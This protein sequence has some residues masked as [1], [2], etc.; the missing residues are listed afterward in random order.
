MSDLA[1]LN[2]VA[3][4]LPIKFKNILDYLLQK[5]LEWSC[6]AEVDEINQNGVMYFVVKDIYFPKQ[7]NSSGATEVTGDEWNELAEE[8][9]AKKIDLSKCHFSIHSHN[10]MGAFWSAQ[11]I[12]QWSDWQTPATTH[13]VSMVMSSKGD[14][15][16]CFHLYK[17]VRVDFDIPIIVQ[18]NVTDQE[19]LDKYKTELEAKERFPKQT[20][21]SYYYPN[22]SRYSSDAYM[23]EDDYSF[24]WFGERK[25]SKKEKKRNKRL[26]EIVDTLNEK[27]KTVFEHCITVY[28]FTPQEAIEAVIDCRTNGYKPYEY[29]F[30]TSPE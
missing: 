14:W 17:P 30:T 25:M 6:L 11:D 8:L 15:K 22:D 24:D 9:H 29:L 21:S 10:S 27:E 5:E 3:V 13:R 2:S 7:E 4:V 26:K 20:K 18:D 28:D 19:I 1:T 12:K 16:A 23:Y